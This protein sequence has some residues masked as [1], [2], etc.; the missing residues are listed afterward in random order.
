MSVCL[1][2]RSCSL[3]SQFCT[4]GIATCVAGSVKISTNCTPVP[5]YWQLAEGFECAEVCVNI[6]NKM[7]NA[8][9]NSLML[10][11]AERRVQSKAD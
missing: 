5:C 7:D 3:V 4:R 8:K 2:V 10:R 6:D 11:A 9:T 1:F